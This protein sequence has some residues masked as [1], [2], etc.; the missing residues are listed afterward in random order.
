[1]NFTGAQLDEIVIPLVHQSMEAIMRIYSGAFSV[2]WKADHSPLTKADLEAHELIVSGLEPF[3]I[4]VISEE[5]FTTD[6]Y[7]RHELFWLVDPLDGTKE[8]ISR[9]GE[10]T[11]NLALIHHGV[12]MYGAIGEPVSG[13]VYAGGKEFGAYRVEGSKK[14]LIPLRQPVPES[15]QGL[16]VAVSRSHL[17]D[18][19]KRYLAT[20]NQPKIIQ[21]G[22]SLKFIDLL[23]GEADRYPRFSPAMEWDIAAGHALLNGVGLNVNELGTNAPMIY[24]QGDYRIR[25]FMA[26]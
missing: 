15:T 2:E 8:F 4:P 12:P 23:T 5:S 1:M 22:S 16:R 11:V 20:L 3:Q 6:P 18:A 26:G 19:T 25:P 21:K 9:N 10:F 13:R 7:P 17:D 24:G 14:E